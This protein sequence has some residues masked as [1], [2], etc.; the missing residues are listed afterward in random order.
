MLG[1]IRMPGGSLPAMGS[2]WFMPNGRRGVKRHV[3]HHVY[4]F[5]GAEI[6]TIAARV[7]YADIKHIVRATNSVALANFHLLPVFPF[8]WWWR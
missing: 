5:M 7:R 6:V 4:N 1:F 3:D 2:R 8:L